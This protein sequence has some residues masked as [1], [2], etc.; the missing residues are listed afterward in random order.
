MPNI[1]L[2]WG[3]LRYFP[4]YYYLI[5]TLNHCSRFNLNENQQGEDKLL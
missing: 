1:T 2:L 3:L 4:Y 5:V